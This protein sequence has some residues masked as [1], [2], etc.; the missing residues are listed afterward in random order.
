MTPF[1]TALNNM[2]QSTPKAIIPKP[3]TPKVVPTVSAST[4]KIPKQAA[5]NAQVAGYGN[6][7]QR[8]IKNT[9][10]Y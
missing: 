10:S 9:N 5:Q 2:S 6:A 1:N 8:A 3:V 7:M 4:F